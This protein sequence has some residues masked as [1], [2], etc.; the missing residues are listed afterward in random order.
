VSGNNR[1]PWEQRIEVDLAYVRHA[2]LRTDLAILARTVRT[3]LLREGVYGA[4][5]HVRGKL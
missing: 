3:V 1:L 5:G 2:S 4:D